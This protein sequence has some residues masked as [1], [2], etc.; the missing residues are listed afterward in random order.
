MLSTISIHTF[1][2][3]FLNVNKLNKYEQTDP[4]KTD[5]KVPNEGGRKTALKRFKSRLWLLP[6]QQETK[7]KQ[8]Q[9]KKNTSSRHDPKCSGVTDM[10]E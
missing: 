6:S 8:Q 2:S 3:L 9:K 7:K 1:N 4:F 10:Y 5:L